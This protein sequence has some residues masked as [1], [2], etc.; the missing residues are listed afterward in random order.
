MAREVLLALGN[1]ALEEKD[2]T[3]ADRYYSRLMKLAPESP[4]PY[5]KKGV[6]KRLEKKGKEAESLFE[7][8]LEANVD[9]TPAL[10]QSLDPL[11][12]EKKVDEAIGKVQQQI[13]KSPKNSDYYV[14]LGKL[15]AIK[16]DFPNARKNFEKAYEINSNN[17]QALFNLAQL[18]QSQGSIDNALENY[19]KMRALNPNNPRIALLTA[20]TLEKKGEYKKA[21]GIYEEVLAGN[22]DSPIAANNLAFSLIQHEPTKENF[23][24]AEKIISPLLEKYKSSPSLVDTGAWVYYH[25]GDY[26]KA[27]DLLLCIDEKA[28]NV[29]AMQYHLGMIYLKLNDKEKAKDYLQL[30]LKNGEKFPGREEAEQE[31][32]KLSK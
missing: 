25:K 9:Y 6:V 26:V 21:Q 14:V 24:K 12:K 17:Q 19:E 23:L 5:Y 30:S 10:I 31:I 13:Q 1:M 28:R 15:Y 11:M 27:R 2:F 22:P 20:M 16:K 8:A 3:E 4:V 29:P 7:K 32:K 18:E